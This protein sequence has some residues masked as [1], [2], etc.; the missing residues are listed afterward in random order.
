MPCLALEQAFTEVPLDETVFMLQP[1]SHVK[2]NYELYVFRLIK[3]L[4]GT[5]QAARAFQRHLRNILAEIGFNPLLSDNGTYY[6]SVGKEWI[7]IPTHVDDLFP[8]S[9]SPKLQKSTFDFLSRKLKVKNLGEISLALKT[10]IEIDHKLGVLK[11]SSGPYI[12]ELLDRYGMKN[13]K[14][15]DTPMSTDPSHKITPDDFT[16]QSDSDRELATKKPIRQLI[17]SL[18]W[19]VHMCRPDLLLAVHELSKFM[20]K[21]TIKLWKALNRILRYLKGTENLGL[22]MVKPENKLSINPLTAWVDSDWGACLKTRKSRSGGF[23]TFYGMVISWFSE[24]QTSVAQSTCESECYGVRIIS[25]T[26]KWIRD[27]LEQINMGTENPTPVYIDNESSI[28]LC[29][30]GPLSKRSR[31]YDIAWHKT[32]ELAALNI[33]CPIF[34]RTHEQPADVFTKPLDFKTFWSWMS[35]I[36]GSMELQNHFSTCFEKIDDG[37]FSSDT[38]ELESDRE[39]KLAKIIEKSRLDKLARKRAK[40]AKKK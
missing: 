28:L 18:W 19:L 24:M 32:R 29:N 30:N 15:K 37:F 11:L 33:I 3:A 34:I 23:I 39:A 2:K 9:N 27:I 14:S 10:N 36:M 8:V 1:K 5:K 20:D 13:C 40:R 17:G 26:V 21:P 31:H 6:K 12:R 22:V 38:E 7:I 35:D 25:N 4:Y 16:D